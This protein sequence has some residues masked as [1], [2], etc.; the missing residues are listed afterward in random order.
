MPKPILAWH[1]ASVVAKIRQWFYKMKCCSGFHKW[2]VL[3]TLRGIFVGERGERNAE[4]EIVCG[5]CGAKPK[6]IFLQLAERRL[7]GDLKC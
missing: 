2:C 4:R 7:N 3:P 6:S 5:R 1:T